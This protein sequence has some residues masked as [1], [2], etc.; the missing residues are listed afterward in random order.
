MYYFCAILPYTKC[1]KER[2]KIALFLCNI[3]VDKL[4]TIWYNISIVKSIA[5]EKQTDV[6][7]L[8]TNLP[9]CKLHNLALSNLCNISFKFSWQID[10]YMV[11]YNCQEG[12]I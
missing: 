8:V 4:F 1:T 6:L 5:N 10:L 9:L 3:L 7:F 12:K 2:L 11:L